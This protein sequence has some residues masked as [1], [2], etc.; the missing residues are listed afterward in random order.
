MSSF[1]VYV[2]RSYMYIVSNFIYA[3]KARQIY[4][5]T[6][7]KFTQQW[8]S[9]LTFT[10]M[11][12]IKDFISLQLL[13]IKQLTRWDFWAFIKWNLLLML[14]KWK[15]NV[16]IYYNVGPFFSSL[17]LL[18]LPTCCLCTPSGPNR[19]V[20]IPSSGLMASATLYNLKL[21]VC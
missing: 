9:T 5:R 4:A 21:T 8:K 18:A 12:I 1:Y 19:Y 3:R 15:L 11:V 2:S 20:C 7:V 6:H 14:S 16:K 10:L 17:F 13:S